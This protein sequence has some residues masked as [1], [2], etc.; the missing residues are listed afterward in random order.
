MIEEEKETYFGKETVR[1]CHLDGFHVR[2]G[3]WAFAGSRHR[4]S[5]PIA[6]PQG[7]KIPSLMLNPLLANSCRT[8]LF[9]LIIASFDNLLRNLENAFGLEDLKS[10]RWNA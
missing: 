10:G 2:K 9:N 5:V 7:T 4:A 3:P 8:S 1:H 6:D